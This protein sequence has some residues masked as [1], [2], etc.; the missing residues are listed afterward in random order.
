[1]SR[2]PFDCPRCDLS[3]TQYPALSR[4]DNRTDICSSCGVLEA[5]EDAGMIPPFFG[6]IYWDEKHETFVPGKGN[7]K[8]EVSE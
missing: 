1:M 4:R 2:K 5:Y 6:E 3:T 7:P 8:E